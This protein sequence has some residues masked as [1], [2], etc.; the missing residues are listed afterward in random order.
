M[1]NFLKPFQRLF[2]IVLLGIATAAGFSATVSAAPIT[3]AAKTRLSIYGGVLSIIPGG[4]GNGI[5]EFGAF[6]NG[7]DISSNTVL[8]IRPGNGT[9]AIDIANA[10]IFSNSTIPGKTKLSLPNGGHICFPKN[11]GPGEDCYNDW[12]P[13]GPGSTLWS[14][15][16]DNDT[17]GYGPA[18]YFTLSPLDTT[19]GVVVG[20]TA[21]GSAMTVTSAMPNY[22]FTATNKSAIGGWAMKFNGPL[23]ITGAGNIVNISGWLK[24]QNGATPAAEVFHPGKYDNMAF[25]PVVIIPRNEGNGSGMDADL[26]DGIDATLVPPASCTNATHPG[27]GLNEGIGCICFDMTGHFGL[28]GRYCLPLKNTLG[29]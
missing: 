10:A 8:Y 5:L 12:P 20:A 7:L 24:I 15:T 21:A 23:N 16:S 4:V 27:P 1:I 17:T 22:A 9:Q 18:G 2:V 13:G 29:S 28:G 6:A 25:P 11:P 3:G 19:A 26:I 14:R